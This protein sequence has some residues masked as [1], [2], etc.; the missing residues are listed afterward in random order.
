MNL[1]HK[2]LTGVFFISLIM[3][4]VMPTLAPSFR[5][6]FFIPFIIISYY[7]K[8]LITCLWYSIVCGVILDLLTTDAR[9]GI[10]ALTYCLGTMILYQQR[11]NF[12][13]DYL[14]TLPL[15]VLFFSVLTTGIENGIL[16]GMGKAPAFT[17]G[18][19]LCDMLLLPVFDSVYAFSVFIVPSL[20]FGKR[21]MKGNDYFMAGAE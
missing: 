2:N 17:M 15:M 10:H 8:P 19:L 12:F 7:Q 1:Y 18:W 16:F 11:K 21:Q 9:L 4:L 5:F 3:A 14:T 6:Y 20:I 13:A